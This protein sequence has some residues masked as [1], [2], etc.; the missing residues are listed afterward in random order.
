[1][2]I[3]IRKVQ[4]TDYDDLVGLM[5]DLGYPTTLEELTIRFDTLQADSN[6]QALVAIR[7]NQIFGFAG[8]CKAL[9]FEFNGTYVRLL[10]FVVRSNK[11]KTGIGNL[12]LKACE[13]WAIEQGADLITLNSGNREE[14]QPAHTFYKNNG[15]I[16]KSTGFSKKLI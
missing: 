10:A 5:E 1:M 4:Q 15:Y 2:E 13:N 6:Y 12:L 14:R 11:R 3:E 16:G 8:L 9:A 7:D